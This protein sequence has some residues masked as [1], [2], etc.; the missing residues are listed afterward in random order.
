MLHYAQRDYFT[1]MSLYKKVLQECVRAPGDA[2]H[3]AS[4]VVDPPGF[5]GRMVAAN[6]YA[7][8]CLHNCCV[9]DGIKVCG[10][11]VGWLAVSENE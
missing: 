6:N 2:A 7:I 10:F 5:S 11:V 9:A 4:F 3:A 8:C 1:A